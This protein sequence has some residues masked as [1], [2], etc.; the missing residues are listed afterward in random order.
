MLPVRLLVRRAFTLIE[1]LVVIAIIALLI[2]ILLPA[3]GEARRAARK[4][5]CE[6]NYKQI[7]TA[8]ATYSTDFQDRIA[9]F[10]WR[11][12]SQLSNF[13]PLNGAANDNDSA[14]N[15]ATD[16]IRRLADRPTFAPDYNW[17]PH[18]RYSH[19][20]LHDYLAQRIPE[21]MVVCPED[22]NRNAWQADPL[23]VPPP[24]I[25]RQAYSSSYTLV[26]AAI[27]PDVSRPGDPT[28]YPNTANSETVFIP[29][30]A[31]L[32]RRKMSEVA[33]P[34]QKVS[35]FDSNARHDRKKQTYYGYADIVQPVLFFD[36]SVRDV[37]TGECNK[38]GNPN[39][40]APRNGDGTAPPLVL[41]YVPST[42]DPPTRSGAATEPIVAY[43]M[44][45]RGGLAGVDT[46][47]RD[48]R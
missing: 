29:N 48:A 32:G 7:G 2:A 25:P 15:Q 35:N 44:W 18:P 33:Y 13:I 19:L 41:T 45:T 1:L 16:I 42:Y 9:S 38:G 12:G 46:G 30:A 22:F 40:L 24:A 4:A 6:S 14:V 37:R 11:A 3:L 31:K 43:F 17:I 39:A 21:K 28:I 23:N 5:V 36:S 8:F 47:G 27:S 34:S 20:V 10:T 26:P